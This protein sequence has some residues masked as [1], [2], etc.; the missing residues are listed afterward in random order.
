VTAAITACGAKLLTPMP[1]GAC[2]LLGAVVSS[3]DAAAVFA[4]LRGRGLPS[5]VRTVLEAESGL[6]DP[7][8][9][10]LVAVLTEIALGAAPA[11][12][13]VA[14]TIA[15]SLAVGLIGGYAAGRVAAGVVNRL[16]LDSAGLYPVFVLAA[17]VLAFAG[18]NLAGATAS[19]RCTSRA[20]CSDAR[21]SRTK[22][23]SR[24]SSTAPPR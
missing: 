1:W 11:A 14:L 9:A 15:R 21:R 7:I 16:R 24:A 20:C 4:V 18:T 3:T 19:S 13:S 23:R 6:N 12:G 5:R 10:V 22:A 2:L 8:A 17:G